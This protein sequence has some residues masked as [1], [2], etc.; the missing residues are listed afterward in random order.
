MPARS[1]LSQGVVERLATAVVE[2][3]VCSGAV[4]ERD[5]RAGGNFEL[6]V[7]R[8]TVDFAG[9][10]YFVARYVV[11]GRV[12]WVLV[13]ADGEVTDWGCL[14]VRLFGFAL[15]WWGSRACVPTFFGVTQTVTVFSRGS[16]HSLLFVA[17]STLLVGHAT[18]SP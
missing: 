9:R 11:R 10:F 12:V 15:V 17:S 6:V 18:S 4:V 5:G 3:S 13:S 14:I 8:G 2:C 1:F 16:A 7:R